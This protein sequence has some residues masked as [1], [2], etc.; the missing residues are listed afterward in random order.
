MFI[1]IILMMVIGGIIGGF[2]NFLAIK[3]LF[4]PYRAY[5][6][7]KWRVPF[8]PGLIPK[9]RDELAKQL[10]K[11]VVTHLLTPESLQKKL[12]QQE[13]VQEITII[14]QNE[15]SKVLESDKSLENVLEQFQFNEGKTKLKHKL[16]DFIEMTYERI[17]SNYRNQPIKNVLPIDLQGKIETKIPIISDFI[18]NKGMDYFSSIEGKVRI[19]RMF[20]DFLKERGMLGNMLQMFLGNASLAD[21]IQPELIKFLN[22]EG[23]KDLLN[24]LLYKEWVKLSERQFE[25]FEE[26]LE[27]EKIIKKLQQLS[28]QII[29]IDS[30]MDRSIQSL[31]IHYKEDILYKAVPKLVELSGIWLT[32]RIGTIMEK[33]HLSQIVTEQVETFSVERVEELVLSIT[34]SELK[35]ITYLG[36]LLGAIIGLFQ[37]ILALFI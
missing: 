11:M 32:E 9:R 20:D 8:T 13:F 34:S 5:Y 37:G 33:I 23:T 3:M 17:S 12:T 30:L 14:A 27:K 24:T 7:G 15:I 21:K 36:F 4:R 19:Q 10:G 28:Q 22:S 35:M 29:N 6:I 16:N 2:T 26:W 25:E 31:T 1:T 18:I